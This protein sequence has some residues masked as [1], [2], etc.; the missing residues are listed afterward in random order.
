MSGGLQSE[1]VPVAIAD[2]GEARRHGR[3]TRSRVPRRGHAGWAIRG[4]GERDPV[5]ILEQQAASRVPDLVP[6]RYGRML[7]SAFAFY[8]GAAAI[9]ADDLATVASTDLTVQLCGDAHLANFGGFAAPDRAIVFDINDFDETLPGP[10]EWDVKRLVASFAVAAGDRGH[11]AGVGAE[12]AR[13]VSRSYRTSISSFAQMGRLDVWYTRLDAEQ[14]ELRWGQSAGAATLERLHAALRKA[15]RKTGARAFSRYA[16]LGPDGSVQLLRNPPLVI[17]LED[18]LDGERLAQAEHV[19]SEALDAYQASLS[20]E[21]R[22]LLSGY[23]T[24]G[25]ARKVV[26]VG[27]VGT[28]CWIVL[29]VGREDSMDDLVLQIKEAGPSVLEPCLG[30]SA[31]DNHGR[32]VVEG[33]RL[34]QAASD[35]LLGWNRAVNVDGEVH[36]FYVRQMWDGK[37]S[38]DLAAMDLD[39]FNVYAEIC[40]W[41]LA[42]A[43]A[44]SGDPAAIAGYLG[45]AG[46]FDEAMSRFATAYAEQNDEDYRLLQHAAESGRIVA[47]EG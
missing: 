45:G 3:A 16:S 23:R 13:A 37:V 24:V 35:V 39:G 26:G 47:R 34:T 17:P 38:A 21:K 2:S 27:S 36:D 5:A 22:H 6:I 28:R 43:H 29:M 8:R 19:F 46:K 14:L 30:A 25:V 10:F 7:T 32:R 12:L 44:R 31:Y 18:L 40:G 41:T 42:R 1:Q 11:S 4:P 15:R 20:D 33:Q 9:M